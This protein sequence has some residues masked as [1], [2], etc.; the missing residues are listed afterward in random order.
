MLTKRPQ[1]PSPA[2]HRMGKAWTTLALAALTVSGC[3]AK[4]GAAGAA[5]APGLI[6]TDRSYT[7]ASR[8][9]Q[10][11]PAHPDYRL[12]EVALS[13][14]RR[15]LFERA[16]ATAGPRELHYDVFLPAPAPHAAQAILLVH[17]G[18]WRS[19]QKSNFYAIADHLSQAGYAVILPEFRLAPEAPYPAGL[20]DINAALARVRGD[21]RQYGIDP[22]RIAIGGES[23]GGQMAA[24]LAYTCGQA[25][26]APDGVRAPAVSALVDIDGVIDFTT[27]L[28]LENEN[29]AGDA[30]SAARWLGGSWEHVPARWRE[31][32]AAT[33][34]SRASPP[35]LVLRG[36]APRFTAGWEVV[37]GKLSQLG[38]ASE[39]VDFPGQPH[40]FW[41]F[42][43][44]AAQV[45]AAIDA[46]LRRPDVAAARPCAARER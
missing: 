5:P 21:A 42:E 39:T 26:Y 14:G 1:R 27:P 30:S 46:F 17:G 18:A 28:A 10:N 22:A 45:S 6:P 38:I 36:D 20:F 25:L 35:T 8:W 43:P 31:A 4:H 12:P 7:I 37:R 2:R 40:T 13:N 29:R 41:L 24:L 16:Y 33:H 34:V 32:S 15:L 44:Y 9:E 11:R 3:A 19:G 23:S